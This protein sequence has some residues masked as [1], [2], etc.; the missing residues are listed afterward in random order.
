MIGAS[1]SISGVLGAYLLLYPRARVLVAIPFSFYLHTMLLPAAWVLGCWFVLQLISSV[2][3]GT[4]QGGVAF[5]AHLGGFI[6]GALLIPFFKRRNV[7]LFHPG[8]SYSRLF[9]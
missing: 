7:Q 3:A 2:L 5:R 9:D 8:R 1:G 4:Q 6:I